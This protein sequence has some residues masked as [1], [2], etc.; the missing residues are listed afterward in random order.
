MRAFLGWLRGEKRHCSM[1][2][3]PTAE[4]EDGRRPNR[5]RENLV[6]ERTRIV[7]QMARFGI[8]SFRPT[9]RMAAEKLDSLRIAEETP[10]SENA[11]AELRRHR[12]RPDPRDRAGT[13]AQAC[14]GSCWRE[15]SSRDGAASL[16]PPRRLVALRAG[17]H[18]PT[19]DAPAPSAPMAVV[20]LGRWR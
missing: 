18:C 17:R 7:N 9:H 2:A 1:A 5:E 19:T 6:T 10:L 13:L 15:R 12:A 4:E 14:G 3:I 16:R 8:R 20:A 11:R